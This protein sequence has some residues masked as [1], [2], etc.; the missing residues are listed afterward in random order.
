MEHYFEA[1]TTS[2]EKKK[3]NFP[4]TAENPYY[5]FSKKIRKSNQQ[6]MLQRPLQ[7]KQN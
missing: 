2:K 5:H 4:G 7:R 6:K 1:S 3:D